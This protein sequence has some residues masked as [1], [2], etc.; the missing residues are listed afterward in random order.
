MGAINEDVNKY[1][2]YQIA[3]NE[4][5]SVQVIP[6]EMVSYVQ[7]KRI[8]K[9]IT[10]SDLK[11]VEEKLKP[12]NPILI[13]EILSGKTVVCVSDA[14]MP[15]IS[16]P[17]SHLVE[18]AIS[19][20]ID[21]S[22]LPGANAALSALI[23]SGLDTRQFFFVG[24][25][26]RTGQ[27]RR[28]VLEDVSGIHHTLIFYE[29][30]HHLRATLKDLCDALGSYRRAVAA[31]E[32]TKK[33]EEFRRDTLGGLCMYYNENEPRGEFVIIVDGMSDTDAGGNEDSDMPHEK[34]LELAVQMYD[35]LIADGT[36]KKEA[37]R[38]AAHHY[39]I[40]RRDVYQEV[41]KRK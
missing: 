32:L 40:S 20:G 38:T 14:G 10:L 25:L 19:A 13:D 15:G 36:Q 8:I 23:C 30:P 11:T 4:E 31:R 21:V 5:I 35:R 16:D 34:C 6:F 3:F 29:A 37:M 18:L 39:G 12:L 33:F 1:H 41:E 17:G 24:F 28:E 26:P 22:P 2:K 9:L 7:T 27:K